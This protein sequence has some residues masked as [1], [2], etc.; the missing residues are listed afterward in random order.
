MAVRS[1]LLVTE[2]VPGNVVVV[3]LSA[4]CRHSPLVIILREWCS[5]PKPQKFWNIH[6]YNDLAEKSA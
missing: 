3:S 4:I 2:D 6:K 5:K 1:G